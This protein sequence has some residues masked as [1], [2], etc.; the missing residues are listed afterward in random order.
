MISGSGNFYLVEI[1]EDQMLIFRFYRCHC[2]V[3]GITA[4]F[5]VYAGVA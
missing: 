3:C 5:N 2:L 1:D 4:A